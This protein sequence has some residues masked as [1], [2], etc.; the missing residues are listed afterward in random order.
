VL[1]A[2]LN[3]EIAKAIDHERICLID[4]SFDD[5]ELLLGSPN[6]QLLLQEDAGLLV[7]VAND[8]VD[9]VFPI[10]GNRLVQEATIVHWLKGSHVGLSIHAASLN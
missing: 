7:I 5:L 2:T 1:E 4:D 6:F 9:D 10:A 8:L 3:E